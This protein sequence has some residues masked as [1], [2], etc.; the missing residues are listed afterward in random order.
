[1]QMHLC[2]NYTVRLRPIDKALPEV[3]ETMKAQTAA[4]RK[5]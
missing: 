4:R 3:L 5:N 1:M 2:P